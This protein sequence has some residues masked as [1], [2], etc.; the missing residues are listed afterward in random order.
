MHLWP[1]GFM[2]SVLSFYTLV[3]YFFKFMIVTVHGSVVL[4]VKSIMQG[5]ATIFN[6]YCGNAV[7][8]LQCPPG[9]VVIATLSATHVRCPKLWCRIAAVNGNLNSRECQME[10][11]YSGICN[12]VM[13]K[14]CDLLQVCNNTEIL[15]CSFLLACS[16]FKQTQSLQT[17]TLFRQTTHVRTLWDR[18]S[19]RQV[20]QLSPL[21]RFVVS[22][23]P[24]F[25]ANT[26]LSSAIFK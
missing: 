13:L 6:V 21:F 11:C 2:F 12:D 16:S 4:F 22:R 5:L 1:S 23:G 7:S 19:W 18:F 3:W 15:Q 24:H 9:A 14:M 17:R 8:R 26:E 10:I 25:S 20:G